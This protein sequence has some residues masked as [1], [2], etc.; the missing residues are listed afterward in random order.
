[1]NKITFCLLV[2][3]LSGNFLF[4]QKKKDLINEIEELKSKLATTELEL[5]ESRK[6]EKIAQAQAESFESQVAGL[7][8]NN[9]ALLKNLNAFTGQANQ[10]LDKLGGV[11]KSL[12]QKEKELKFIND[13][14]TSNDSISF[15]VLNDFKRT[16]GEN[17]KITLEGGSVAVLMAH[18]D[19]F[20]AGTGGPDLKEE[21][22]TILSKMAIVL[23][24]NPDTQ[25]TIENHT[26]ETSEWSKVFQDATVLANFMSSDNGI[27][28]E[29][30]VT[31]R[32]T[33]PSNTVHIKINPDFSAFYGD[34]R[35]NMKNKN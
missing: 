2:L 1:M 11:M 27:A 6:N 3:T 18:T 7:E 24:T 34:V 8:E 22:K 28:A 25:L 23:K 16:L 26:N 35:E 32:E 20:T 21:A 4:S 13:Q 12:R 19:L 29:R 5:T 9:A 31:I 14:L 10:S 30:I 33:D 17:V 15:L